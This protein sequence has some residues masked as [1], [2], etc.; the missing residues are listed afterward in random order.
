MVLEIM[1]NF[2]FLMM[3]DVNWIYSDDQ[4]V[5]YKI[6]NHMLYT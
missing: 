1:G 4:F 2:C 5:I 6:Q 3:M